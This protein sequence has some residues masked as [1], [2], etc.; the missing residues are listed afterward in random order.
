MMPIIEVVDLRFR[1]EGSETWSIDGLSLKASEGEL[2]L[3]VGPTGSGKSTLLRAIVGL[4]PHFYRGEYHGSVRVCGIDVS[5]TP[6][7][8]VATK[9]GMVFQNPETQLFSTTVEA[10]IAFP[11]ENLG[12]PRSEMLIRVEE[13]LRATGMA[14]LRK[15]NPAELSGGQKQRLA[16]ASILAMRPEVL[17]LDEPTSMLDPVSAS[18]ILEFVVRYCRSERRTLLISEHRLDLLVPLVDRMV[19]ITD[20]KI[21]F[22]GRP[23]D[24]FLRG[25]GEEFRIKPPRVPEIYHKVVAAVG[26]NKYERVPLTASELVELISSGDP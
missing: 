11:L 20:G 8:V 26:P 15:R 13:A 21:S 22:D 16:I 6:V 18:E 1:Y 19:I 23:H 14:E 25:T 17:V 3:V 2:V 9:V 12:V 5:N 24:F 10:E 7:H 4:V